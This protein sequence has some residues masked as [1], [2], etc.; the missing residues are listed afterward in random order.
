MLYEGFLPTATTMFRVTR[1]L[2]LHAQQGP[3]GYGQSLMDPTHYISL[4]MRTK[5]L[6]LLSYAGIKSDL[7]KYRG[8]KSLWQNLPKRPKELVVTFDSVETAQDFYSGAKP[9][10]QIRGIKTD[11]GAFTNGP[12]DKIVC[13]KTDTKPPCTTLLMWN[14]PVCVGAKPASIAYMLA[15]RFGPMCLYY[16]SSSGPPRSSRVSHTSFVSPL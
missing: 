15:E 3:R 6:D 9:S 8:F 2:L 4:T 13:G 12:P 14:L 7:Q 5:E 1:P 11:V 10:L 16:R